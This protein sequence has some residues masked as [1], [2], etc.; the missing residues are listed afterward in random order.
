MALSII[1][2][3]KRKGIFKY[4]GIRIKKRQIIIAINFLD[5]SAPSSTGIVIMPSARSPS[6]S[7]MS[8]ML[9]EDVKK[10]IIA[11]A[12]LKGN[13]TMALFSLTKK[14]PASVADK[15]IRLIKKELKITNF[16]KR[17]G[18]LE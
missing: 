14:N 17:N 9:L 10:I 4:H 5:F 7:F 13:A 6:I 3:I 11:K 18:G 1:K 2:G 16:L 8:R 15:Q 12:K